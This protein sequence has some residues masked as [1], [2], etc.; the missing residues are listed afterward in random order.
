MGCEPGRLFDRPGE[1]RLEVGARGLVHPRNLHV[2]AERDRTDA[3][4]DPF[5]LPLHEGG[6]EEDVEAPRPHIHRK[7]REEVPGLVDEDQERQASDGD[8]NVHVVSE[9]VAL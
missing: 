4:L 7:R 2:A 5:P 9:P 1:L 8:E 3:V 6:R